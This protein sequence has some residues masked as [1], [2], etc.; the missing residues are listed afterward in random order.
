MRRH[1]LY[2]SLE[3]FPVKLDTT[4]MLP[5][6]PVRAALQGLCI[7]SSRSRRSSEL[8]RFHKHI[9]EIVHP[10]DF[11]TVQLSSK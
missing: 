3:E 9:V 5:P 10:F 6:M 2:P 11:S 4:S 7:L 8:A 1:T